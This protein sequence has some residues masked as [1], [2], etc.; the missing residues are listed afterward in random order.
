MDP[1]GSVRAGAGPAAGMAAGS[2][3]PVSRTLLTY[4]TPKCARTAARSAIRP[5]AARRR[6]RV[7]QATAATVLRDGDSSG[8]PNTS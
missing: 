2:R 7:R 6:A 5:R 4:N 8:T 3:R 1:E